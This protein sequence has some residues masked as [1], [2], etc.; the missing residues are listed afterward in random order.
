MIKYACHTI[1]RQVQTNNK[2]ANVFQVA[3]LRQ[4]FGNRIEWPLVKL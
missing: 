1:Q 2:S 4:L 3:Q